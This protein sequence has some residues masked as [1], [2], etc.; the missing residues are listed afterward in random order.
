ME[1]AGIGALI[2]TSLYKTHDVPS[3]MAHLLQLAPWRRNNEKGDLEVFNYDLVL[4]KNDTFQWVPTSSG[5]SSGP[6]VEANIRRPESDAPQ[7]G[8]A[9]ALPA[10]AALGAAAEPPLRHRGLQ[11]KIT[12][13][14]LDQIPPLGDLKMFLC[15]LSVGDY[16]SLNNRGSGIKNPGCTLI[17]LVPQVS[18]GSLA[19]EED[20]VKRLLCPTFLRKISFNASQKSLKSTGIGAFGRSWISEIKL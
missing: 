15:R 18:C 14:M 16:S 20:K 2:S 1:Q 7:R 9:L 12:D 10:S 6:L 8:A 5:W 17:E 4:A 13:L 19:Q 3:L 11:A